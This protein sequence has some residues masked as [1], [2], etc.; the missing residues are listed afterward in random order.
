[1]AIFSYQIYYKYK[2][3][4]SNPLIDELNNEEVARNIR[5]VVDDVKNHFS[6]IGG[7]VE[8]SENSIISITVD[9]TQKECDKIIEYYLLDLQLLAVKVLAQ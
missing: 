6:E 7:S 5:L 2:P 4:I 1:M 9:L 3:N 8:S